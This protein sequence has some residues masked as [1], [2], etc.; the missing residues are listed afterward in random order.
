MIAFYIDKPT[1]FMVAAV[2]TIAAISAVLVV[3]YAQSS[4]VY[5]IK[6]DID[7]EVRVRRSRLHEEHE[8]SMKDSKVGR[9]RNNPPETSNNGYF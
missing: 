4:L 2:I 5:Q 7:T 8:Q 3:R 9:H 6:G 1:L